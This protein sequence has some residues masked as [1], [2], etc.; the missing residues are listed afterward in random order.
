ME[1]VRSM[2]L[3]QG[4]GLEL[5]GEAVNTVVYIKNRC[6]TKALDSKPLKKHG[7]VG[8]LTCLI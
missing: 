2:I 1:C 7:V 6:P 5:W 3:A 4:L 8:N